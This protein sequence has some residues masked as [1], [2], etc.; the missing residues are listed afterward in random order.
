MSYVYLIEDGAGRVKIG[1]AIDPQKRL[2][3]LQTGSSSKLRILATLP[4]DREDELL[5]HKTFRAERRGGEWF[6]FSAGDDPVRKFAQAW[7]SI[8]PD[9]EVDSEAPAEIPEATVWDDDDYS[10]SKDTLDGVRSC[11][12]ESGKSF[13]SLAELHQRMMQLDGL[14]WWKHEEAT[15]WSIQ[16]HVRLWAKEPTNGG[17]FRRSFG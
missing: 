8:Q 9:T 11:F 5:L 7:L 14:H 6:E 3:Q 10:P 16:C 4:G 2:R 15:E 13:L 1:L 12:A 17:Y